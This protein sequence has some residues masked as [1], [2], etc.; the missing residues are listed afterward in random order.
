VLKKVR[1]DTMKCTIKAGNLAIR[2]NSRITRCMA[3]DARVFGTVT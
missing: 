2:E 1:A 3:M